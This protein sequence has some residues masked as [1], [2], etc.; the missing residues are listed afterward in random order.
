MIPKC[1]PSY[2]MRSTSPETLLSQYT[3][4]W[5][6]LHLAAQKIRE[7]DPHSRDY[8]DF[9]SF[10][11]AQNDHIDNL[12]KIQDLLTFYEIIMGHVSDMN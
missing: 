7:F 4:I 3:E 8:P 6:S 1:L 2:S 5:D 11:I 9:E 12:K 10:R